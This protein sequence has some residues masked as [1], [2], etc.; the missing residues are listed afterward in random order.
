ME[1]RHP[2]NDELLVETRRP[3]QTAER[4]MVAESKDSN[5]KDA[6][7]GRWPCPWNFVTLRKSEDMV[8]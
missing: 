3:Q 7:T 8:E 2:G 1:V 4:K 5:R 6:L